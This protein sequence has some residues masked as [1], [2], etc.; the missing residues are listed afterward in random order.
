M[1][2][3]DP[4]EGLSRE[5]YLENIFKNSFSPS[6]QAQCRRDAEA[7]G[8]TY[9]DLMREVAASHDAMMADP[10]EREKWF[11]ISE[12]MDRWRAM[13]FGPDPLLK[14]DGDA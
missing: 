5:E 1:F 14:Q 4:T 7:R 8:L 10:V 9:M 12:E 13:P 6:Q 2:L 3:F 11:T